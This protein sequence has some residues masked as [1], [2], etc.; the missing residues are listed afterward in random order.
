[1]W[2]DPKVVSHFRIFL[3]ARCWKKSRK[4]H[5]AYHFIDGIKMKETV[6]RLRDGWY[7]NT[8]R[9]EVGDDE[10]HE[11]TDC[12]KLVQHAVK[13][14]DS[15]FI[16]LCEGLSGT[17]G[18]LTI[19]GDHERDTTGIPIDTLV[20]DMTNQVDDGDDVSDSDSSM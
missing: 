10:F 13:C 17:I 2:H 9:L 14:A 15:I 12:G 5:V 19:D 18:E 20:V 16:P 6:S 4:N 11:A 8:D 3:V 7:G 1:V